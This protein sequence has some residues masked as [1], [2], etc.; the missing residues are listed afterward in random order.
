MAGKGCVHRFFFLFSHPTFFLSSSL[1][2]LLF[3]FIPFFPLFFLFF[4]TFPLLSSPSISLSLS[5][6]LHILCLPT[7]PHYRL[8]RSLDLQTPLSRLHPAPD[9]L[10]QAAWNKGALVDAI[11]T[12]LFTISR[13]GSDRKRPICRL[14]RESYSHKE[15]LQTN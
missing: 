13:R 10:S 7:R 15:W 8:C 2:I 1:F 4:F 14:L 9:E 3:P 5:P 6:K 11:L 12:A